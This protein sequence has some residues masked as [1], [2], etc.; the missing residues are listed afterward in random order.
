MRLARDKSEARLD[1]SNY[2]VFFDNSSIP[3]KVILF[4]GLSY[5]G[6]PGDQE[7]YL[8]LDEALSITSDLIDDDVVFSMGSGIPDEVGSVTVTHVTTGERV[9]RVNSLGLVEDD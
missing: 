3:N 4:K 9:V 6:A 2:G 5:S 1:N 7:I 8:E